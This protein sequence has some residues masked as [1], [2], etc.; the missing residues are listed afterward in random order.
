LKRRTL[1]NPAAKAISADVMPVWLVN[2]G[3]NGAHCRRGRGCHCTPAGATR[4]ETA[5][6]IVAIIEA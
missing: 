1:P 3:R 6:L 2:T 5:D 4:R